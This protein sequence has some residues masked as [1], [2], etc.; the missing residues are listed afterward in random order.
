MSFQEKN[1]N[2]VGISIDISGRKMKDMDV[3]KPDHTGLIHAR[4]GWTGTLLVV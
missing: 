4:C 2:C 1:M 3:V